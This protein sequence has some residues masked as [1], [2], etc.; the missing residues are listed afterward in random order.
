MG[1]EIS[2]LSKCSTVIRYSVSIVS[3]PKEDIEASDVKTQKLLT[4]MGISIPSLTLEDVPH[5]EGGRLVLVGIKA[6]VLD[7]AQ[8]I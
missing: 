8:I 7:K 3:W 4:I 5:L 6:T 2:T 1:R